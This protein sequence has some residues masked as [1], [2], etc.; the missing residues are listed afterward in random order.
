MALLMG[1]YE[2][3]INAINTIPL[4]GSL[5]IF[6]GEKKKFIEK[7]KA[8]DYEFILPLVL[9]VGL[10]TLVLARLIGTF[11]EEY[12]AVTFSF[13]FGLI[14]ASA[15][16][17]YHKI[18]DFTLPIFLSGI[19]G[20]FFSFYLVGLSPFD[21]T[22]TLPII[23]L[24]GFVAIPSMILPGIS[25]SFVLILLQQYKFLID[26][27]NRID[28]PVIIVFMSGALTGLFSFAKII[29]FLFKSHKMA[30]LVFLFGLILGGLRAPVLSSFE[31]DPTFLEWVLPAALGAILVSILDSFYRLNP[32]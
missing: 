26:A 22:H 21:A 3:L 11:I 12:Q 1:V 23:F 24:S 15:G 2:R 29:D 28:I 19:V 9:G 20:F 8:V 13:F 17:L 7:V 27:L 32:Q 6:R 30:T 16:T 10:A 5:S 25:G 31:A 14:L 4:K 18:D